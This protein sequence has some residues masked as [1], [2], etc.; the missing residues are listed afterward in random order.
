MEKKTL[1]K[2][3]IGLAAAVMGGVL[4]AGTG[5]VRATQPPEQITIEEALS[6]ALKDAG[7]GAE[8]V[9]VTKQRPDIEDGIG[10]YDIEFFYFEGDASVTEYDYEIEAASGRILERS[11]E[12]EYVTHA[13]KK[14]ELWK[15]RDTTDSGSSTEGANA[16]DGATP[17]EGANVADSSTPP[18]GTNAADSGTP[19]ENGGESAQA[20]V[21]PQVAPQ[22][23]QQQ[24]S[25]QYIGL[26]QAKSIALDHAGVGTD[27]FFTK[28]KQDFEDGIVVYEIEFYAGQ[29]EYEY[30][31]DAVTG[32]IWDFDA[33]YDD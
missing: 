33:D 25:Q 1:T 19:A 28:E 13:P 14:Q 15:N 26:E 17:A 20:Q 7:R 8:E 23:Q 24:Q 21:Q 29:V 6:I 31:I 30:E 2:K 3:T 22:P 11:R 10:T 27:V 12:T 5:V 16:A 4:I 9:T 32:A 18:E